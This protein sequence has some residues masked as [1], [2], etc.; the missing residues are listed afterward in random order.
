MFPKVWRSIVTR[1]DHY[2]FGVGYGLVFGFFGITALVVDT[3]QADVPNGLGEVSTASAPTSRHWFGTNRDGMDLLG[4]TLAAAGR[5]AWLTLVAV[6]LGSSSGLAVA[7]SAFLIGSDRGYRA[8]AAFQSGIGLV[9]ALLMMFILAAGF[10]AGVGA[11]ILMLGA[12]CLGFVAGRGANW[13]VAWEDGGDVIS[14]RALG[15]SRRRI[16]QELLFPRLWPKAAAT[17]ATL[18]PAALVAEAAL[19]F[20]GA[21]ASVAAA[22]GRIGVM[23]GV[24]RETMFDLP[25]MIISSG[26][27]LWVLTMVLAG[28]AWAVRRT[29]DEPVDER[30]F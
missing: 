17:A 13:C 30:W 16:L 26:A 23:L 5:S 15:F 14:A 22:N 8:L 6:V 1:W 11:T 19:G 18:L 28:L 2:L 12:L 10:G 7:A 3:P 4:P 21:G 9:P 29:L 27:V 24:G 20:S 25:W